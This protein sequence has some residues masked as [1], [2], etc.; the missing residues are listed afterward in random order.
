MQKAPATCGKTSSRVVG[1]VAEENEERFD[2]RKRTVTWQLLP[3]D[4]V[5]MLQ[6]TP[7]ASLTARFSGPYIVD[8]KVSETDYVIC[9]PDRR[10]KARLCYINMLKRYH[11]RSNAESVWQTSEDLC[12][13]KAVGGHELAGTL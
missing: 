5:L 11:S 13:G 2:R 9:T 6:P 10:R 12:I 7:G 4:L 8:K 1:H 3:G